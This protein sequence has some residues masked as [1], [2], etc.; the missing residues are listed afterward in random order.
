MGYA[1]DY[2]AAIMRRGRVHMEPGDHVPNWADG[3]RK[4]KHYPDTDL[5]TPPST[6]A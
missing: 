3:P 4:T 2:A 6:R 1:Y 5:L